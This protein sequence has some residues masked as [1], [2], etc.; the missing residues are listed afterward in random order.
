M[1]ATHSPHDPPPAAGR[2][3][4]YIG[5][6]GNLGDPR[7]AFGAAM[8]AL[9]ASGHTRV[10]A[11]SSLYRGAAVGG[12]PGQPDYLNAVV[13][14]ETTLGPEALLRELQRLEQHHPR[15]RQVHWGPRMLDLDLLLYA[16]ARSA[17]PG[18]RLPHPHL[19]ARRFVLAP[20]AELAPEL[21]PPGA[22]VPVRV[23]LERLPG[24]VPPVEILEGPGWLS[25]Q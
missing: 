1:E 7:A 15:D 16:D 3:S 4:A 5:L 19:S 2:S 25:S 18:L 13:Q 20:L 21:C 22:S 8:S 12:P 23:L 9:T 10:V 14:V 6:G 11:S 24:S 17:D